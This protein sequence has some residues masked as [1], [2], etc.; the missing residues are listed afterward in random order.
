MVWE[1]ISNHWRYII[2]GTSFEGFRGETRLINVIMNTPNK[3]IEALSSPSRAEIDQLARLYYPAVH[4]LALS[5]MDDWQ[6]AEDAAQESF[7]AAFRVLSSFR[8]ESSLKTWLFSITVNIC[9]GMLRKR[10]VQRTLRSLLQG[11]QPPSQSPEEATIEH[12]AEARL[13]AE[14]DRLD[15]KHRLPLILHYV[16]ELKA[17]EIAQVLDT[18]EGTVHSRL[19]YARRQLHSRLVTGSKQPGKSVWQKEDQPEEGAS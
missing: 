12:E 1:S 6:E 16:H 9:R 10:R 14:V 19:H 17:G 7:I 3:L 15:E 11:L 18:T 5:I 8:H 2:R 4:R 13:W